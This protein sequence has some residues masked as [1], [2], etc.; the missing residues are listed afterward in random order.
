MEKDIFENNAHPFIVPDE[1]FDTLQGRI[2]NRIQ[3]EENF[4]FD[5]VKGCAVRVLSSYQTLLAAAACIL[6][7]FTGTALYMANTKQQH[8]VAESVI[9]DD[10]Y[11]WL[12]ASDR[13]TL[14]AES[15][16]IHTPE[17]ITATKNDYFEEDEAI[18]SFLE[19]NNISVLAI[20]MVSD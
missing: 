18:I 13:A 19:R 9:D 5:F 2:V 12:Y 16:D 6:F 10:F 11:R 14:L 1:Y 15:L 7:I 20:L 17:D 8:T 4:G 3:T